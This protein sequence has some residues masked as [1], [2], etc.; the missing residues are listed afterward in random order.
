MKI[1]LLICT[2][3]LPLHLLAAPQ[4]RELCL[5]G[6]LKE[7]IALNKERRELYAEHTEKRSRQISDLLIFSEQLS[8]VA[9]LPLEKLEQPLRKEGIT[10][11]CDNLVPMSGAPEFFLNRDPEPLS[12]YS[13]EK[14]FY[15]RRDL[16]KAWQAHDYGRLYRETV[17]RIDALKEA[18]DYHCMARHLLESIA[19]AAALA[20]HHLRQAEQKNLKARARQIIDTF[21]RLQIEALAFGKTL[22]EKAAP[23]QAEGAPLLCNDVPVIEVPAFG[24][25]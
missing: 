15:Y 8:L 25:P 13:K 7:A 6:H 1:L 24:G 10:I 14:V 4:D 23:L 9:A 5:S 22:D 12:F 3:F 2:L 20:P 17:A 19:R 18:Q 21:I 16:L 11:L